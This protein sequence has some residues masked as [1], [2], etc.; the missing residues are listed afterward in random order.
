MN[1]LG[2]VPICPRV[3]RALLLG[4][5]VAGAGLSA[6]SGIAQ[7]GPLGI[8][9]DLPG[10]VFPATNWWNLDIRD[11]PV[12]SRSS[13]WIDWISNRTPQY[14]ARVRTL[15]PD[16]G[17]PPYGIP[18]VVVGG[19]QPRV[20]VTWVEYGDESDDGAPG[21]PAGYPIPLAARTTAG[22][23]E[24]NVAGGGSSGDRHMLLVDRDRWLL[25]ELYH[26][27]WNATA[28]RWEAGSGAVF[29]LATNAR[30]PD[31]WTS[32]DAAG[33]AILPGLV[34]YD[35]A[36]GAAE[37]RHAFRVTVRDTSPYVWPA[38][39]QA[40]GSDVA[41]PMG[42][43]L[44]LKASKDLTAYPAPIQRIFRAMQTYG[45]IIADHG[46]DMYITGTMDARWD[47]DVLNPAFR[48]LTADDFEVI[49]AGW[50][51]P[52]PAARILGNF[53]GDS[54]ADFAV[55]RPTGGAWHV[56]GSAPTPWGLPND[57]PAPADFDGDRRLDIAVYRPATGTWL[58]PGVSPVQ[59]GTPADLP[60][61]ADYTG[62]GRA[63]VAVYRPAN[64]TWYVL[65]ESPVGGG[66][67]NDV[68]APADFDGDGRADRARFRPATGEWL[69]PGRPTVVWGLA[70]DLPVPAD[71]TGDGRAEL[72]VFRP[73][74]GTWYV[75]D[76][77]TTA[78]GQA[79][80]LP[81]PVDVD[82]DGRAELTVFRR[83]T[84]Q[85]FVRH[86]MT[87]A[88]SATTFGQA[89]DWPSLAP[90]AWRVPIRGDFDGDGRAEVGVFRP[91]SGRWYLLSSVSAWLSS[92][93]ANWGIA[94]DVPSAIDA[95]GD[96]RSDMIAFRPSTAT[97]YA[98]R[99]IGGFAGGI[100]VPVGLAGDELAS[101][102]FDGDGLA[103]PATYRPATGQWTI[104][105]STNQTTL[106]LALG[107]PTEVATPADFDG[108]RLSDVAVFEPSTGR[109][110]M[111]ASGKA[112]AEADLGIW[113]TAG[114]LAVAGDYDGDGR[115]DP[116]VYRP[117]TGEWLIRPRASGPVL[118]VVWG[119]SGD[120]PV[121]LDTNGDGR[122]EP[123]VFRPSTGTWYVYGQMTTTWGVSSDVPVR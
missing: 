2:H 79:G 73:S 117:S 13:A 89:G 87:G 52:L 15:H 34:R 3:I 112:W 103:D 60:V 90:A 113:G 69:I 59:Y 66:W 36:Y 123:V 23:I 41:P 56:R 43:R 32:A 108:D 110:R 80:D 120:Q 86:W 88:T 57:V 94:G 48:S 119:T 11:A 96:R 102:D 22:Y 49:E 72:A 92:I 17:P 14:P 93:Q 62:D 61:P 106:A 84:G 9:A 70:G 29:D 45:L 16:F 115:A 1:G 83:S 33:L 55:Y 25:F 35:E 71:Y 19:S 40:G 58:R 109:W 63:D 27:R 4:A 104:R 65:G 97:W 50:R 67:P 53:S 47:N 31:G 98:N 116:A 38:S 7:T 12:D 111:R 99:S 101:G 82:A 21:L 18:Y 20:P 30:R 24:G 77:T 64:G 76:V 37:I 28:A 114:D 8:A 44:R 107:S 54:G 46:S 91:S 51:P 95:D 39:H 85:W 118:R 74:S 105:R 75:R 5:L 121:P 122:V 26:T 10:Q 81:V 78:W 6:T 100:G 68:P 42:A